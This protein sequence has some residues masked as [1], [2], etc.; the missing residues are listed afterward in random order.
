MLEAS[1][2]RIQDNLSIVRENLENLFLRA[3]VT[4]QLT[5]LNAEIGESK[6]RGERLG[7]IDILDGF[8][9]RAAVDE[10]YIARLQEGRYGGFELGDNTY[11]LVVTKIYPEVR[12]GR[13]Q[14]DMEFDGEAPEG[15]RR[16]QSV[17]VRLELGDLAESVLLPRGAFHQTTGGRWV[18]VVEPNG[19]FAVKR[20]IRLGQQNPRVCEVLEGLEPGERVVISSYEN[21]GD[22]EKLVF[23]D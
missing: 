15:I 6:R 14:I 21:Y 22:V 20:T 2:D 7:Q 8:K 17:H 11:R 4:G 10:F 16:G 12:D 23:K 9:V 18:Y 13:F 3:P 19:E 5:S 1:V